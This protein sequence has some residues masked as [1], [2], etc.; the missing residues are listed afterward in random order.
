MSLRLFPGLPLREAN[1]FIAQHHRHHKPVQGCKFVIGCLDGERL[2]GC[3]VAGRPVARRLDDG[4]TVELTRVCTD[5]TTHAASKLI[6]G[7]ARAAFAM[8]ARK[9]ISYVLETEQGVSYL[10]AG[11]TVVD[12]MVGGGSW[13]KPGRPRMEPMAD[14][15]GLTDKA[16]TC[17]KRRWEKAA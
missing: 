15:L 10:A 8:G 3:V 12:D 1:A 16:P 2:C 17:R 11:W 4:Y 5:G 14:L 7:A 6:A 13:N 9:V